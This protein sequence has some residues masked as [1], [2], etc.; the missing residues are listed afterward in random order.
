MAPDLWRAL[1][2]IL[3]CALFCCSCAGRKA[4][5]VA[6]L[7][8]AH[9]NWLQKESMLRQ[10]P[11][12]IAQVSQ[13]E[14]VWLNAGEG[15]RVAVLLK[16]APNW[17][18]INAYAPHVQKPLFRFL[19]GELNLIRDS[20]F[21]GIYLDATGEN[22]DI[23]LMDGSQPAIETYGDNA[24]SLGFDS[25][26]GDE[27]SFATLAGRAE[28]LGLQLGST[29][30]AAATGMGPDF[31]LQ[32]ENAPGHAGLYA[33]LAV[34]RDLWD[35][36][37]AARS[38]WDCQP[39]KSE[40]P[41]IEHGILPASLLRDSLAWAKPSG[42]AATGVVTGNDGQQ[43][44]WVYRYHG[45]PRRPVMLWQD[46]S[47]LARRLFS[48]A[49]IRQTGIQGQTLTGLRLEAL[50]GLDPNFAGARDNLAPGMEALNDL[51]AQI[52]R[53][54]GW[55]M[56][57]DPLPP[58]AMAAILTGACDFCLDAITPALVAYGLIF[59]DAR[60]LA[61]LYRGW[62]KTGLDL[63]R[64]A[65]GLE[66]WRGIDLTLLKGAPKYESQHAKLAAAV[67]RDQI[68]LA[69][70]DALTR[71]QSKNANIEAFLRAWCLGLPGLA[72]LNSGD[73]AR[74]GLAENLDMSSRPAPQ[75]PADSSLQKLALARRQCELAAG[76]LVG[77]D[78]NARAITLLFSLPGGN[79]WF[80]AAN[81]SPG[82]ETLPIKIPARVKRATDA[83]SG[84]ELD[85][86]RELALDGH[87]ARN[88]IFHVN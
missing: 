85:S 61:E 87:I 42:W 34:P 25:A 35:A 51:A 50:M 23:W 49:I 39:L 77:V 27:E 46:P 72:F 45:N 58:D 37:P 6:D 31:I 19:P 43:R 11:E 52:H 24:A 7:P 66:I 59:A 68:F 32:A 36:L 74:S 75:S 47:G 26:L 86:L 21:Q 30:L 4:R 84:V 78:G 76:K 18:E 80:L 69:D 83:A 54:G 44:R 82:R 3:F 12:I 17:L 67:T 29:L 55:A 14:R 65:R 9:V 81:F 57:A 38:E 2:L 88:I 28:E 15:G 40:T 71:K 16:A 64:L 5:T 63:S 20:G 79:Y 73:L 56:Q 70:L 60:P 13:T 1:P 53:Y 22:A 10:A 33:M 41:L 48:A 62:L 8:R